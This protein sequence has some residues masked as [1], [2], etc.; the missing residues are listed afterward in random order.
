MTKCIIPCAG[1]GRRMKM[2][3][4]QSKEMLPDNLFGFSHI[5]DY[6]L[7]LCKLHNLEPLVISRKEKKDLNSYLK[8]QKVKVLLVDHYGEWAESVLK[9]KDHWAENNLL[10]LPDTRFTPYSIIDDMKK[11][12]EL[13]NNAVFAMHKVNDPQNW[14]II[15]DYKL[16]EKPKHMIAPKMAWGLI[17]FRK[18]FGIELFHNLIEFKFQC[19]KHSGFVYLNNFQDITRKMVKK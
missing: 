12:L 4:T 18:N 11:G 13:G 16:F 17:G 3:P 10:M 8:K 9:S 2:K 1:F 14:G 6:S 19:L 5:I 15:D 7:M